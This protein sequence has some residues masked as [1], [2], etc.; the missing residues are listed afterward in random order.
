M[1]FM[2]LIT[3]VKTLLEAFIIKFFGLSLLDLK[4]NLDWCWHLANQC[5][6]D[7]TDNVWILTIKQQIIKESDFSLFFSQPFSYTSML[8]DPNFQPAFDY[9]LLSIRHMRIPGHLSK[10]TGHFERM[11][12]EEAFSHSMQFLITHNLLLFCNKRAKWRV[13]RF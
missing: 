13:F 1:P 4:D 11:R 6:L 8:P 7:L 10:K 12:E 3:S 9:F 5:S 2:Y